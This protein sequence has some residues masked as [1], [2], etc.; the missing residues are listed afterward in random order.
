MQ[1]TEFEPQNFSRKPVNP[2][3]KD[4]EETLRPQGFD[5]F[6]GQRKEIDNLRIYIQAALEREEALDHVLL[7]GPPGLGKTTLAHIIANELGVKLKA[8]SGPTMERAGDLAAVLTNLEPR[9]VLFV[10]GIHRLPNIV[11]EFLYPA[12]EDK[13][14][15]LTIGEGPSARAIS[16][17]LDDFTLVGATTRAGLLTDPLRSRFGVQCR[18]QFYNES[19]MFE[20]IKRSARIM[21]V[22]IKDDGAVEIARRSRG[23]PRIANRLLRRVRDFAQVEGDGVID[24]KIARHA[25]ERQEVDEKGLC[26]MD[27]AILR[28]IIEYFEGGPVGI[29]TLAT[30]VSEEAETI[31]ELHE[32]FLIQSGFLKRTSRGRVASARAFEHMGSQLPEKSY[33]LFED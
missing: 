16:L 14:I 24:T 31:E 18:L 29:K 2:G 7:H 20:I 17:E 3:D 32:P 21:D 8:I 23:T 19:Q 30:A 26:R 6:V 1:E 33:R 27:R 9:S 10:D 15:D 4:L 12:M 25:L 28:T 22:R 13:R 11:E 5:E